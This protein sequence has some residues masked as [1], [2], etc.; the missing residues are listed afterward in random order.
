MRISRDLLIIIP[1]RSRSS[2]VK[3][4][5]IQKLGKKNLLEHKIISCLK[6][7]IGTVLV[8]TDSVKLA[9]MS[10]KLG[11]WVP[12]L[13][14]KKYSGSKATM[15]S[16]IIH[17]LNFLKKK[18]NFLPNYV[19]ILP[20]TYPFTKYGSI[21]KAFKILKNNKRINSICSYSTSM[22]HP[23]EYVEIK[24]TKI[25][26]DIIKYKKKVLT[27]YERIQDFPS[28]HVL[29]GTI[30]MTKIDYFKK[31]L[32]NNSSLNSNYVIDNFSCIGF[33]VSKKEAFDINTGDDY[34]IAK[35]FQNAIK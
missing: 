29:S 19:A 5:N 6:A 24:N 26:F 23:F 8:S 33:K 12:F 9:K 35:F 13:R 3:N 14:P 16:C 32:K 34:Q 22:N 7:K 25:H 1:A 21:K 20:P 2:R 10:E 11:A 30:R 4:K 15:M 27:N 31:F 28:A 17:A 18:K